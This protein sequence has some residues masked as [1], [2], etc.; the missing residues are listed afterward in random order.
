MTLM[1]ISIYLLAL[2][3]TSLIYLPIYITLMVEHLMS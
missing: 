3:A 1:S 2:S